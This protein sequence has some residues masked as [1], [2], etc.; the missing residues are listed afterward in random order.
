MFL[1]VSGIFSFN[2][3]DAFT[4]GFPDGTVHQDI[5]DDGLPFLK[6]DVRTSIKESNADQD[7]WGWLGFNGPFWDSPNHFDECKFKEG[8]DRI[9]LFYANARPA[10]DPTAFNGE[11]VADNFGRLLHSSQDFYAHSS[12]V[13]FNEQDIVEDGLVE[14]VEISGEHKGAIVLQGEE[15]PA[16][17][18]INLKDPSYLS[19][20]TNPTG[21]FPILVS[22][23]FLPVDDC[24]DDVG[25]WHGM[26][27]LPGGFHRD[28]ESRTKFS[29]AKDLATQQTTH[30]FCRLVNMIHEDYDV[31]GVRNI[32]NQWVISDTGYNKDAVPTCL[33]DLGIGISIG[34]SSVT[35]ASGTIPG[36]VNPPTVFV[37]VF[38]ID[39]EWYPTSQFVVHL[40]NSCEQKHY[41]TESGKAI[42]IELD[43]ITD[44]APEQCGFGTTSELLK[45]F[46]MMT[47][48][49][50]D[51][52]E[53]AT[54][55][56]V[57]IPN[58]P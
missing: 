7:S 6:E 15:Y 46:K 37:E 56:K 28:W 44:P 13:Y 58:S 27:P 9:N 4:K 33:V 48:D 17:H 24:P 20:I 34:D 2:D 12:W 21:T 38:Q 52:W 18:S 16:N 29:P 26:W 43:A 11:V 54:G 22:G 23:W 31:P 8:T 32:L 53:D 45:N 3:V 57:I 51:A 41:H 39:G 55:F 35:I 40:D 10:A 30:E 5:V 47:Q 19:T 25:L 49:Q 14:W 42:S 1:L 36:G 50:I